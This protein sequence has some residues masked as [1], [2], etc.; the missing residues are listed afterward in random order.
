MLQRGLNQSLFPG[1]PD[2]V[3]VHH[4]F[5][6]EH[7]KI[8]STT[9]AETSK[10]IDETGADTVIVVS[11]SLSRLTPRAVFDL[12]ALRQ[13]GHSSG[14]A[15]AE[16]DALSMALNLASRIHVAAAT[17]GTPRVGNKAWAT[18]FDS[19]VRPRRVCRDVQVALTQLD[20]NYIRCLI[21]RESITT[22]TPYPFF[23]TLTRTIGILTERYT[24]WP[25]NMLSPAL[26][27]KTQVILDAQMTFS[28][29]LSQ[30]R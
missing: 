25:R 2:S 27:T 21:S 6:S 14:A 20:L 1:I 29:T 4:Q 22:T 18:F 13:V 12:I 7:E 16:L 9:L 10:L 17:Y 11:V 28:G 15:L 26:E 30:E 23:P 8:A 24:F 19:H 3:R 5:A